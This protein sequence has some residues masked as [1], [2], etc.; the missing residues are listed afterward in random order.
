MH[1]DWDHGEILPDILKEVHHYKYF[2]YSFQLNF[3]FHFYKYMVIFNKIS[4]IYSKWI[5]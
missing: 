2:L 4:I 3:K 5:F 1:M